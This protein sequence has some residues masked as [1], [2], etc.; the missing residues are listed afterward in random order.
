MKG[1]V[2]WF[3]QAGHYALG[4]GASFIANW[5][6]KDMPDCIFPW[7]INHPCDVVPKDILLAY[8]NQSMFFRVI[9]PK[10][11]EPELYFLVPDGHRLGGQA[12][13]VTEAILNGIDLLLGCHVDFGVINE[14][15]LHRLPESAKAIIYPIPFCPSDETYHLVR[16]FVQNGGVLYLSGDISYDD[17][18]NR[19]RQD[20]LEELCGVRYRAESYPN[21]T[22]SHR[23][24]P[25]IRVAPTMAEVLSRSEDGWP[26]I[27]TNSFGKGQVFYCTDP[28]EFHASSPDIYREFLNS[29]GV[30]RISL[31][32][33][34]PSIRVFR[35]PTATGETVYVL[36]NESEEKKQVALNVG[37]KLITLS[38]GA[39]KPG[40]IKLLPSGEI[41][42]LESQG[43]VT[44]GSE[45]LMDTDAHVMIASLDG[46]GIDRAASLM[47]LPIEPGYLK[48]STKVDRKSPV[49]GVGEI[50]GG[51]WQCLDKIKAE[52]SDGY[53]S[54]H[55]SLL[56]S[57]NILLIADADGLDKLAEKLP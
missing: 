50:R 25:C 15:S 36:F 57:L 54:L 34:D 24:R 48:I 39:G 12:K 46:Q 27:M 10:Y 19:T 5:D 33:D 22:G 31:E 1:G 42:A 56:Q 32:P 47:V 45:M 52:L 41:S 28:I 35:L 4:M 40:L 11:E 6:W 55:I 38:I 53:L 18:R 21:I 23:S 43:K 20:R 26:L 9:E 17:Y 14:Y 30:D 37:D 7:G 2:D 3:L 29:A 44:I 8:R 51:K 13:R 49:V 16:D